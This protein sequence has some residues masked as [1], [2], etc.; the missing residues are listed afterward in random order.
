MRK[1]LFISVFILIIVGIVV[2]ENTQSKN[3][4][5]VKIRCYYMAYACG[6]CFANYKVKEILEGENHVK[7]KLLDRDVK[8]VFKSKE[9][10]SKV[11]SMTKRCAICYDYYFE[12]RLIYQPKEE[13]SV[14]EAD[15][16]RIQLRDLKCCE[17]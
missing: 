4:N 7:G 12:G 6:D 14:L 13:Y 15:T 11:D 5:K 9:L 3:A 10:E 16:C 1:V 2:V 17:E 8:V